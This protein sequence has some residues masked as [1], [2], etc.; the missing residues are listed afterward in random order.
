LF[1]LTLC[2][3]IKTAGTVF[4]ISK[5]LEAIST[6]KK[7]AGSRFYGCVGDLWSPRSIPNSF[8]SNQ[9]PRLQ[10]ATN[11][12]NRNAK[13]LLL[14]NSKIFRITLARTQKSDEKTTQ[15]TQIHSKYN[16]V[17]LIDGKLPFFSKKGA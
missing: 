17:C 6:I 9:S 11:L 3:A 1:I 16:D 12:L 15:Q 14:N 4:T 10:L 5:R 8:K 7:T 13:K 2:C